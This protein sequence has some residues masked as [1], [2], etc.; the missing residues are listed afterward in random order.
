MNK[1][2]NESQYTAEVEN[3]E[4]G[5]KLSFIGVSQEDVEKQVSDFFDF[6]LDSDGVYVGDEA[7]KE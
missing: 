2:D 3:P 7:D 1:K 5:T 4:D 6:G